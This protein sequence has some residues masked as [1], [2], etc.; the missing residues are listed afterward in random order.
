MGRYPTPT[1]SQREAS[2]A[3]FAWLPFHA[4]PDVE[5]VA[6]AGDLCFATVAELATV[7]GAIRTDAAVIMLDLSAVGFLDSSGVHVIENAARELRRQ[8]RELVVVPGDWTVQ[9]VFEIT[10]ATDRLR[11]VDSDRGLREL[12][13]A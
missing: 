12:L 10:G 11:F 1:D 7:F 4:A 13:A 6:V 8:G 9:R 3:V 2:P 5:H